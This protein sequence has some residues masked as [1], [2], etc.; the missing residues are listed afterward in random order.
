M[1]KTILIILAVLPIVLLVVIAFAGWILAQVEYIPVETV[2]FVDRLGESYGSDKEFKVAQGKTKETIINIEPKGATNQKVTYSSADESI[3]TVDKNGVITGVHWG[4][5][6]VSVKTDDSGIIAV[7]KVTVTADVPFAVYL[8]PETLSLKVT[9]THT[10]KAEVDAPVSLDRSVT[11]ASDNPDVVS[12][13]VNGKITARGVGTATITVTTV[14]GE[15]TDTC[16]VTVLDGKPPIYFDIENDPDIVKNSSD[17][18]VSAR[19]VID[20]MSMLWLEEGIDPASVKM[21]IIGGMDRATLEGGVL[22]LSKRGTVTVR[23]SAVYQNGETITADIKF[24]L[25]SN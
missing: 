4:S 15:K 19:S 7:L 25:N 16:V 21:E 13:D 20:I 3:C 6:T 1:K 12:V 17:V 22:T 14:L 5:T 2:E 23:I 9:Q 11:Y 8:I 10:L 18:H 24:G